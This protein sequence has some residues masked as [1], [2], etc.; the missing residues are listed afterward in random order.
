MC[1]VSIV[2]LILVHL[3][4]INGT[5]SPSQKYFIS[6]TTSQSLTNAILTCNQFGMK[7]VNL[8][9]S[10]TIVTDVALLNSSLVAVNCNSHFWFASGN[11][12]GYVGTVSTLGNILG[13]L[14]GG[15]GLLLGAVVES[16]SCLIIFC[17]FTTTTP[18]PPP[19]TSA[20]V[21]C[22]R[23]IQNRVIQKCQLASL[24]SN[25]R[26]FRF[27]EQPMYGGILDTFPSTSRMS[28]SGQC[29]NMNDCI[30]ISYIDGICS[31]YM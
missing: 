24:Q 12:T 27:N 15:L 16:L 5:C 22:V 23:P 31:L 7:L 13:N 8:T 1:R 9:N 6:C 2:L 30:G 21:V 11:T 4:I 20:A 26:T 29:S 10:S 18:A 14:L 17:P 19:I 25:M 3:T 28:C